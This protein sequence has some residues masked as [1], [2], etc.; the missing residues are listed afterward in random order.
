LNRE[1]GLIQ[2]IRDLASTLLVRFTLALVATALGMLI[3][4]R[5]VAAERELAQAVEQVRQLDRHM[6]LPLKSGVLSLTVS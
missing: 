5:A 2:L 4:G 6:T 3:Y 1:G